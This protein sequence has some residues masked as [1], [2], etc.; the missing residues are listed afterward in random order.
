MSELNSLIS[1]YRVQTLSAVV[2]AFPDDSPAQEYCKRL[3]RCLILQYRDY[4]RFWQAI[5]TRW[6]EIED[7]ARIPW[8]F[9]NPADCPLYPILDSISEVDRLNLPVLNN[10]VDDLSEVSVSLL[11]CFVTL[12]VFTLF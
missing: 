9:M 4:R 11:K 6:Q 3:L 10:R 2:E 7:S 1:L 12:N 8:V 5:N